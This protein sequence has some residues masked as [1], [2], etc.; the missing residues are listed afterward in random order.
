MHILKDGSTIR[1]TLL[2]LMAKYNKWYAKFLPPK[3]HA[4]AN[5]QGRVAN[6]ELAQAE[7]DSLMA[8]LAEEEAQHGPAT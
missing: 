3:D 2:D 4:A 6:A 1:R 8:M 5:E 7:L